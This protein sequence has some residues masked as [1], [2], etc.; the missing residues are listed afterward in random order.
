MWQL[1]THAH[2]AATGWWTAAACTGR[3]HS[4]VL[5]K[6]RL[7]RQQVHVVGQAI[8]FNDRELPVAERIQGILHRPSRLAR[9]PLAVA[10]ARSQVL[11]HGC[12]AAACES[13][14]ALRVCGQCLSSSIARRARFTCTLHTRRSAS[15][16]S[17]ALMAASAAPICA[18]NCIGVSPPR[19][20]Q[21]HMHARVH[22][23]THAGGCCELQRAPRA[24]VHSG[25]APQQR[26]HTCCKSPGGARWTLA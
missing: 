9:A 26:L 10:R 24:F 13:P 22:M 4:R 15:R 18:C 21:A 12:V 20:L 6:R 14:A 8:I 25:R 7:R 19:G 17:A 1:D 3:T 11:R 16:R 2:R 5:A 23:Q